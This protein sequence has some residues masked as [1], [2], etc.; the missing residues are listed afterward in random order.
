MCGLLLLLSV[1]AF[2]LFSG[3][4]QL[5]RSFQPLVIIA[6]VWAAIL[7]YQPY[8]GPVNVLRNTPSLAGPRTVEISSEGL[9]V[10]SSLVDSKMVWDLFRD[11]T[12]SK[13]VFTLYHGQD[14]VV[15]SPKRAMTPD[16]QSEVRELLKLH[17][18]TKR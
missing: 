16:Q 15:P 5:F 1:A 13:D 14:I 7:I 11:W 12:E 2:A 17:I 6:F 18:R 9:H 8:R 4:T 3:N 10:R